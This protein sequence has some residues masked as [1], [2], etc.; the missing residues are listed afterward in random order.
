MFFKPK[1]FRQGNQDGLKN[2]KTIVVVS[3][4]GLTV[5][6]LTELRRTLAEKERAHG[7]LQK[8]AR[9]PRSQG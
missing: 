4:Q 3:Y 9:R 2:S 7:C 1:R 8:H 5:A 6:E